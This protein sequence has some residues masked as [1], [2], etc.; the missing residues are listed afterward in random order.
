ML[1][2][3]ITRGKTTANQSLFAKAGTLYIHSMRQHN[4]ID[5][6]VGEENCPGSVLIRAIEPK[7]GL[8]TM[9]LRRNTDN[10][11][12]LCSGPGKLCK[13]LSADK[14]LDGKNIFDPDCVLKVS[15]PKEQLKNENV[16]SG[17]RIG[18]TK[19]KDQPLRFYLK[20]SKY[21]S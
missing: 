13:A 4:L 14:L 18:I 21:V 19:N 9:K 7:F 8:E 20:N 11:L 2:P 15:L 12:N 6:V 5:I 10:E 17:K 1:R 16:A 3:I